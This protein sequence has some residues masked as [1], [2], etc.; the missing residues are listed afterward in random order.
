VESDVRMQIPQE[1][2]EEIKPFA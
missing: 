2:Q 1:K